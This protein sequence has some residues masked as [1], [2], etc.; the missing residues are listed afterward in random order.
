MTNKFKGVISALI[1]PFHQ[2][3]GHSE[4]D[5]ASL[6]KLVQFQIDQKVNGFVINGTTGESPT[7]K[8]SEIQK[9]FSLIRVQV[10]LNFPLILG[11]GSNSTEN[12]IENTK[13]AEELGADAALVVVP[14]YNKPPQRG[15]I[16]HFKAIARSTNL[17]IILYNVPGR[18]ITGLTVDTILELSEFKNIIGIKEASGNIAFDKELKA[19]LKNDFILLS[20]DDGTYIDF[21]AMGGQGII[22]VMSNLIPKECVHWTNLA[23]N[24]KIR[25]AQ[26]S[27]EKYKELIGAMYSE[28]NPIPIK[29]ML[30]K[31][32]IIL[33]AEARLPL[34]ELDQQFHFETIRIMK[35][36][37]VL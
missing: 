5:Y 34:C 27:F 33:S 29:W 6:E 18:T 15:L 8:K 10:G 20:G 17:P 16:Q 7:L 36:A 1:T 3:N 19:K 25:E 23:M 31:K 12:T 24:G 32:N 9:I 14:Y 22:S 35:S 37:G 30:H 4:V 26:S 21:L 13:F 11:T 28:A 2:V